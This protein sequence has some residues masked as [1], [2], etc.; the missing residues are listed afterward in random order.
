MKGKID[1]INKLSEYVDGMEENTKGSGENSELAKGIKCEMEEHGMDEM[2]ATKTAKEH[3]AEDPEY[4]TKLEEMES[5]GE[6]EAA[7]SE[8][9]FGGGET[10]DEGEKEMPGISISVLARKKKPFGRK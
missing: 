7:E 1:A 3:L 4:Y 10:E 6:S 8:D 2:E 5:S 9:S